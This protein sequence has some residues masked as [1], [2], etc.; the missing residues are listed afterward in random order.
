M[1]QIII[2]GSFDFH[3]FGFFFLCGTASFCRATMIEMED[4]SL[5]RL[6]AKFANK[7]ASTPPLTWNPSHLSREREGRFDSLF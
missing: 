6:N 7:R 5:V 4:G 3:S 2:P 1:A